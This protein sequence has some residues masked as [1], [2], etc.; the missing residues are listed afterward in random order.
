[1]QKSG[2]NFVVLL[3][4][5]RTILYSYRPGFL[6]QGLRR[7][8][9]LAKKGFL[10]KINCLLIDWS[11]SGPVDGRLRL[12]CF[13]CVQNSAVVSVTHLIQERLELPSVTEIGPLLCVSTKISN[14]TETKNASICRN[15]RARFSV[16]KDHVSSLFCCQ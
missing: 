12:F 7:E 14:C 5:K 10:I 16:V 15:V 8:L 3:I 6:H 9:L 2:I 1:M 11:F 13:D 4:F